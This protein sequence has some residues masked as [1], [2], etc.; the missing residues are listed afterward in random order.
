MMIEAPASPLLLIL[1]SPSG[2]GKSSLAARLLQRRPGMVFS[3]SHT[4]R[5]PR[6]S[7]R[8]GRDYWFVSEERFRAR[9]EAG[10]FLEWAEVHG[11]LYGTA[12][13]EVRG[14]APGIEAVLLDIDVQGAEQVARAVPGCVIV[15]LLPPDYETLRRRLVA[16]GSDSP[17]SI[18]RR[19]SAACREVGRIDLARYVVINRDL[20][21]AASELDAIVTAELHRA[22]RMRPAVERALAGFPGRPQAPAAGS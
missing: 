2:G 17:E 10:D 15:F 16:R 13:D 19:L 11:N 6:D 7:E 3:V 12:F 5:P 8:D 14:R 18:E 22:E 1:L 9:I 4:T 21:T 20:E